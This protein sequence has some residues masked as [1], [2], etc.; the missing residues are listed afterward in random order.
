MNT[1]DEN[2][3]QQQAKDLEQRFADQDARRWTKTDRVKW[4]QKIC[5]RRFAAGSE[6][7]RRGNSLLGNEQRLTRY[8]KKLADLIRALKADTVEQTDTDLSS[9]SLPSLE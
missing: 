5:A 3:D 7:R 2:L 6:L 9:T 4:I 1:L 8:R